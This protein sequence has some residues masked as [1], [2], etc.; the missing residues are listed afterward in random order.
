MLAYLR[1]SQENSKECCQK[2]IDRDNAFKISYDTI[3]S[4]N[5]I[6]KVFASQSFGESNP[7]WCLLLGSMLQWHCCYYS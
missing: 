4:D 2:M 7:T 6:E 5:E 3:E 1:L